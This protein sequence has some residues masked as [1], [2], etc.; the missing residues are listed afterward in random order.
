MTANP[1]PLYPAIK[2][3]EF[4]GVWDGPVWRKAPAITIAE[5]RPESSEHRPVTHVKLLYSLEGIFGLFRVQDQYVR[6]VHRRFQDPVYKDSCVEFFVQPSG[7]KGYFNFEFNC[8]GTMLASYIEDP[9]RAGSGFRSFKRLTKRD[10]RLVHVYHSMPDMVEPELE[11]PT[12]WYLEF[13]IHYALLE[14]Y[15]GP[16]DINPG[17]IWRANLFKCGDQTSHP[18]WAAW[19]AVDTLN[20]HL[21]HCFGALQFMTA[22]KSES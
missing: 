10:R 1:Y 4:Q 11:N 12:T 3:P 6:C 7:D 20:F 2:R 16:L 9:T 18:H 15:I 8:G 5:F 22:A 21:P 17:G 14:K 19:S 13:Y